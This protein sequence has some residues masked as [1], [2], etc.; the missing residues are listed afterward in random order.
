MKMSRLLV[1][2]TLA[3]AIGAPVAG[4]FAGMAGKPMTPPE[5]SVPL[6]AYLSDNEVSGET[7]VASL[8]LADGWLNS[9]PLTPAALHGK[10]VL[11][12]FW[13]YTCINWRRTLPY[14]R[15]WAAKYRDKGLVVVGVHTPEFAFEKDVGNVR[16]AVSNMKID[17]PVAIDSKYA[18]WNG[19]G[20]QY[21]PALYLIDGN[22]HIRYQT[23]GEG[24]YE[25]SEMMIQ[26]LL[27]EAGAGSIDDQPVSITASGPEVAADSNDLQSP[28][29]YVGFE[30][31]ENFASPGGAVRDQAR[32]YEFP[33]GLR[34]NEWALSGGWTVRPD[35]AALNKGGGQIVYRFHA[36]DL[37]LVMG[38]AATGTPVKFR[39]LID[40]RPPGESH[41]DDVDA[42]GNGTLQQQRLYQLIRQPLP[43]GDRQFRIEFLWPGVEV[44]D[45][46]F[47]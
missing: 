16:W 27:R 46:T 20:N 4:V 40:G 1:T 18:V 19:F 11:V 37:N 6:V 30:R 28:E 26:K 12:D 35:A 15:R 42:A 32:T 10:V 8:E 31:A 17:Y 9:P 39:V 22:G 43:I 21:W 25:Q 23:F 44:F 47:G 5:L 33:A 3:A 36:R 24:S 45:F 7:M 13:T 29:S 2:A 14:I 34:L 41:G 38:P